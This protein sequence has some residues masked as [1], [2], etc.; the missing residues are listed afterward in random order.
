MDLTRLETEAAANGDPMGSHFEAYTKLIGS[1]SVG[2]GT[3]VHAA[4]VIC[5]PARVSY[6]IRVGILIASQDYGRSY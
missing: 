3:A 5:L 4:A 1:G 6:T 2:L